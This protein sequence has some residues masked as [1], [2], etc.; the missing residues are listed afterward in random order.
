MQYF[1]TVII[2]FLLVGWSSSHIIPSQVKFGSE[3]E[4]SKH[5]SN[6]DTLV[7]AHVVS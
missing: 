6:N 1:V 2:G 4:V 7:F 3:P 5:N